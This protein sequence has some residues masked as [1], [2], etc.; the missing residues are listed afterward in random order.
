V[1]ALLREPLLH[2]VLLGG[3]LFVL[4]ELRAGPRAA[5]QAIVVS[6][7]QL[8]HLAATFAGTWLR[9]PDAAELETLIQEHVREELACREALLLGLERD[10]TIVRRR[11]RQKLEFVVVDLAAQ[12]R[13]S[14]ADLSAYLEAHPDSFRDE[15]RVSFRHAY[16]SRERRGPTLESDGRALLARLTELDAEPDANPDADPGPNPDALGDPSLLSDE[17]EQIAASELDALFGAGFAD[18]LEEL[19]LDRWDG[20]VTSSYGLHIV[21]VAAR[22]PGRMPELAEVRAEVELAWLAARRAQ[23]LEDFYEQRLARYDV[24]IERP[25]PR[26]GDAR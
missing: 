26:A 10:D 24:R 4:F 5:P 11:L 9:P 8:E 7:G 18:A 21:K 6:A 1:K 14:E 2:F 19:A 16:L 17:F 20:P 12:Q 15:P 3:L 23:E 25:E 13:P 22:E